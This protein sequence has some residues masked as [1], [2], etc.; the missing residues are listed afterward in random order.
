MGPTLHT[1]VRFI[2]RIK[3]LPQAIYGHCQMQCGHCLA[4]VVEI[5]QSPGQSYENFREWS[6]RCL[7]TDAPS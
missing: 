3:A 6:C 5:I 1:G 4:M 2:R 7:H